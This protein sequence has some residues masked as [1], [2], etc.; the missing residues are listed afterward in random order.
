[1]DKFGTGGLAVF[2][3]LIIITMILGVGIIAY[4]DPASVVAVLGGTSANIVASYEF[5]V[6]KN[7]GKAIKASLAELGTEDN[8]NLIQKII[9]YATEIKKNGKMSIEPLVEK[10]VD[11]FVKEAFSLIIDGLKPDTIEYLLE[12]KISHIQV[13]HAKMHQLFEQIASVA[14]SMGMVGT[15]IG[16]VA[17]LANLADPAAVGP[18]M[19]IAL[20]TTLYGSLL[21][22]GFAGP[23]GNRLVVKSALE[24]D[25][26]NII[27]QGVMLIA[28]EEP[29]GDMKVKLNAILSDR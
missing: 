29:I 13:R 23:I 12:T 9:F 1:M 2:W 15:L 7:I 26:M 16:L 3:A 18:A 10:E 11:P 17:M 5:S 20:L 28:T 27:T 25:G 6:L 21:G 14:G 19:A 4:L 22:V 24:I 8:I